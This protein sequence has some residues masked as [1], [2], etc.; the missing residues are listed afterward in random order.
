MIQH[1]L[2]TL[3]E[4]LQARGY[5][6][7]AIGK[8]HVGMAF[9]NGAGKPATD[10][11]YEDVDFTRPVL[12]GPTHHGLMNSSGCPAT[13]RIRSTPSRAFTFA[14]IAGPLPTVNECAALISAPRAPHLC[15]AELGSG[16]DRPRIPA[17]SPGLPQR[18]ARA[19]EPFFLYYVPNAN[20]YQR[21]EKDGD[22]GAQTID[23]EAVKGVSRLNDGTPA[24]D[25][26]DMILENDIAFGKLLAT[27]RD[28][29][30]PRWRVIG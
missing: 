17:R 7:A 28:T 19:K 12:D 2:K 29:E 18:Q 20:H 8:Y 1:A 5:R 24:G 23:G 22:Y 14:T 27:L 25:R 16:P 4:M 6:T 9:D 26:G 13:L 30:D 11:Y 21:N 15:R 3:P 10:Y